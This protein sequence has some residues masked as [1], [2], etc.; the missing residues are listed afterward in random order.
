MGALGAGGR[1]FFHTFNCILL[2]ESYT[3]LEKRSVGN[4][5]P[6]FNARCRNAFRQ[7]NLRQVENIWVVSEDMLIGQRRAL[8]H[9]A[10]EN[11]AHF[12]D[13]DRVVHPR[14]RSLAARLEHK[15]KVLSNLF[16]RV[17]LFRQQHDLL[18]VLGKNEKRK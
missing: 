16:A 4:G 6:G 11:V 12:H 15:V 13:L 3:T 5:H 18:N 7:F 2:A 14:Q 10:V 17:W 9:N 8:L 1:T